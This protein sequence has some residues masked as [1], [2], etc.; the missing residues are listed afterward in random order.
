[1]TKHA[2]VRT[3]QFVATRDIM[4]AAERANVV[5]V[6]DPTTSKSRLL[7]EFLLQCR[8]QGIVAERVYDAA[9]GRRYMLFLYRDAAGRRACW[10]CVVQEG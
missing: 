2:A 10:D 6:Y 3:G 7:V 8:R 9:H 1:M 4:D 5:R